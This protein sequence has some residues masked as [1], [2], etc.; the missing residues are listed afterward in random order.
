MPFPSFKRWLQGLAFP[1][2]E[3]EAAARPLGEIL[4]RVDHLTQLGLSYLHP[5]RAARTLSGGEIQRAR[6]AQQLG[7]PLSGVLYVLDEPS[8]GLH[9]RDHEKLLD[10]LL[11]LRDAG[12][13]LVVVEHDARTILKADHVVDMGPGAGERGGRVV[14]SGPPQKLLDHEASLTAR[15]VSGRERASFSGKHA[16][17]FSRGALKLRGAR[18]RN[19]KSVSVDIPLGCFTC[20]TGVS[21][22]GKSTLVLETLCR[23]LARRL[24]GSRTVPEPFDALEGAESIGRII[25]V[26][27]M[28][29]GRTAR[30]TPA[31]YLGAFDA[32][33]K[34]FA[35]LPEAR[36]RGYG[37]DRFSF[38]VKGGRCE[39]CKGE[40]IRRMEMVFLPDASVPCADCRGTRYAADTLEIVFKGLSIAGVLDSTVSGALAL[41]E[42][43]PAVR[44][45]LEVLEEVGLGYLRLG[46]PAPTLSGGEAQRV[47][48]AR[49]LSQRS[50]GHAL[51]VLDEPTRGLHQDDV[52]KLLEL[53][54]RLLIKGHTVV[55]IEHHLDVIR[56]AHHVIDLGPEGGE[57][58]GSVVAQGPPEAI[59]RSERSHTGR[60]L[61][62]AFGRA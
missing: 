14:F 13:T 5:G 9:P 32:V 40:G 22:S 61:R 1:A 3:E 12:N 18:G 39:T 53:L 48:L 28:P 47:K 15:Y 36:A 24:Q 7:S 8:T 51:Y 6:L 35:G 16:S 11:K 62:E 43:F 31:T 4:H 38:N 29:L 34:I 52:R 44:R 45:K 17:P 10:I 30:S 56:S 25:H 57:G 50:D 37:A 23:E 21:G 60:W 54:D 19:L 26:D 55:M 42:H 33:R 2:D 59:A 41:F 27:Q 46:Q 49:E 58:G 20:V